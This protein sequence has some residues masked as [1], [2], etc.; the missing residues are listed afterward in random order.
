MRIEGFW[1]RDTSTRLYIYRLCLF[2]TQDIRFYL[3]LL[4]N[5]NFYYFIKFLLTSGF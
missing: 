1:I 2:Q 3:F 5:F 4:L